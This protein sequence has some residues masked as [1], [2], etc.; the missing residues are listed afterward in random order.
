MRMPLHHAYW[1]DGVP[2]LGAF[3]TST[4]RELE[5]AHNDGFNLAAYPGRDILDPD[6]PM[7]RFAQEN[8]IRAMYSINGH[9]HGK[10]QLARAIDARETTIP[11]TRGQAPAG[12]G[13]VAVDDELI[14]YREATETALVGCERGADGTEPA[15]H[16][17]WIIL[18]WPEV[19]ASELASVVGSRNLWGYWALDDTP[20]NARSAMRALYRT[21]RA[22]D[23]EHHPV[24]GGYSGATTLHNFAPGTCDIVV[25]YWYPV[26]A[27]GYERT[28]TAWDTQQILAVVR[29]QVPGI[30]FIGIY[31]AF[32]GGYWNKATPLTA[33]EVR[34][35]AEDF[36][37]EGAAGLMA[38]GIVHEDPSNPSN[39]YR[40]WQLD[41]EMTAAVREINAEVRASCGMEVSPEPPELAAVRI[42]PA[43]FHEH[44]V[45][46]PGIPPAWHVIGP[47]DNGEVKGLDVVLPPERR[48]DLAARYDGKGGVSARWQTVASQAGA[49][50][51]V[52][53]YGPAD[54]ATAFAV[55]TVTNPVA[56]Q[57]HLRTG[58]DDEILVRFNG[59]EV[60][61]HTGM[62]GAHMDSDVV[63][64]T[65]PAGTTQIVAKVYNVGNQWGFCFRFTGTDGK[66]LTGLTFSPEA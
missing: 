52:E 37:R 55:C 48:I 2:P 26:L 27:T 34:E 56:R 6:T 41:P 61:R 23:P 29:K 25:P 1:I 19:L 42:Q 4:L 39:T 33:R 30:P 17:A 36:V 13:L 46:V 44:A 65:L 51:L 22:V 16:E 20:G 10:P 9:I 8:G 43:G 7:G 45:D 54:N 11:I 28:M 53:L 35:Q 49:V 32:W 59:R 15:P 12:P 57:V 60:W 31:Q 66:P 24:C 5:I 40:G 3:C 50:G 14:R 47:F 64:V 18:F 58:S 38:F 21:V 63:P 62:R